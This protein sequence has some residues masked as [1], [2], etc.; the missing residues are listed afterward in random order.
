MFLESDRNPESR[1]STDVLTQEQ[2]HA[3]LQSLPHGWV[4]DAMRLVREFKFRNFADA[5]DFV[6]RVGALAE[7]INHH[8]NILLH[9]WNRVRLE[10]WTHTANGLSEKD[11]I[12][13][14]KIEPDGGNA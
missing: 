9:S 3:L 14:S 7:S 2:A 11:F 6:N 13:A 4:V 8:P 12:L 10:V 5:L 1:T